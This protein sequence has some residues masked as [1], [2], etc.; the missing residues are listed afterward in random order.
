VLGIGLGG[1]VDGIVLH[2]IVQWH[3][4]LS[5]W[6]PPTA[7]EAMHVN[8][9]WDGLLH[10]VVW[11]VTPVGVLLLWNAAYHRERIPPLRE[12]IGHLIFGGAGSTLWKASLTISFL[13]SIMC[14]K[15]PITLSIT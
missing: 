11:L 9:V 13:A 7:L 8:M 15:S 12:F 14:A 5:N 1:C 6:I 4:M 3:N 10:A 2:Q